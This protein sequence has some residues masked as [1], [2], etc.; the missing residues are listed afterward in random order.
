MAKCSHV[1][2]MG[3]IPPR[4]WTAADT[5]RLVGAGWVRRPDGGDG[6]LRFAHGCSWLTM[7][8]AG[9]AIAHLASPDRERELADAL[10]PIGPHPPEG[11]RRAM[12]MGDA[13]LESTLAESG[14][15]TL[16][17]V[18][19]N[20][21]RALY[22]VLR[23]ETLALAGDVMRGRG[24]YRSHDHLVAQRLRFTLAR[25]SPLT[26]SVGKA[27]WGDLEEIVSIADGS[28]DARMAGIDRESRAAGNFL[29]FLVSLA[30]I[31]PVFWDSPREW[32]SDMRF[33]LLFLILAGIYI[34]SWVR[35]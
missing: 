30:T 11:L 3:F 32:A 1:I 33:Y 31:I 5:R 16:V 19:S 17:P 6:L 12:R 22:G 26:E 21:G 4:Q 35:K 13:P 29:V 10:A 7:D 9:F 14:C 27:Q 34:A 23:R 20:A 25:M 2:D 24:S 18:G 28:L 8:P 15:A